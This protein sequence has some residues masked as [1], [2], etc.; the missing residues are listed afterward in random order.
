MDKLFY[1]IRNKLEVNPFIE[2][3]KSQDLDG[4]AVVVALKDLSL[5][6]I[7]LRC[8]FK[9]HSY[10]AYCFKRSEG[11]TPTAFKKKNRGS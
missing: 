9:S 5:E 3:I 1:C 11:I 10:F 4:D 6:E 8:G 7:A 2:R